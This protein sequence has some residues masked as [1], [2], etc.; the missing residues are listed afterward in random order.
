MSKP[1]AVLAE[2][3]TTLDGVEVFYRESPGPADGSVMVHLHGFGMSGAY[4]VPTAERLAGEFHTFVPDLPGFG[5][6]GNS[7]QP[8]DVTDLA[9]AAAAF[10]DDRDIASATLVG[11]SMGCAV[12]TEFAYL[13]PDRLDRAVLVAPAG[14]VHNQPLHRAMRQ[15]VTDGVREPPK[16]VPV[17]VPDYLRFGVPSTLRLFRALTKYP[18]GGA[19]LLMGSITTL[20]HDLHLALK[21]THMRMG[22][23]V[24]ANDVEAILRALPSLDVRYRAQDEA[25]RVFARWWAGRPEVARVLHPALAGSPGHEHW[26]RLCTRAAGLFSIVFDARFPSAKVDAFI[27]ALKLF[28]IGYSW[29]GPV[30]LAVPYDLSTIRRRVAGTGTLVRFSVG[31]EAVEDLIADCEQA[32]AALR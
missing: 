32:L 5:R 10:L 15:L 26:A 14:G 28:K 25:G 12:I 18:S 13:Y 19:D 23:G 20:D 8:L 3:W 6:S 2:H 1:S 29:A 16:L 21:M 31:L 30:S 4:L 7:V 27:D 17:A 24:G 22:W 11:N 9:H